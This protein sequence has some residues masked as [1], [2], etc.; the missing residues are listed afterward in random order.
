MFVSL[1]RRPLLPVATLAL[2]WPV[3]LGARGCADP[4]PIGGDECDRS[5]CGV[6]LGLPTITC[7]DGS[8]GGNTG[9]CIAQGDPATCGWEVRECPPIACS[10]TECGPVPPVVPGTT[11]TCERLADGTC[12]WTPSTD[13]SCSDPTSCGPAPGIPSWL[14]ADGSA[15][16]FTG[17]CI[18][19]AAGTCEWEVRACDPTTECTIAECGP[20][21]GSP[22]IV[23]ADG[24][25][26]GNTGHCMRD[27]AT[28]SCGWEQ[29]ACPTTPTTCAGFAGTACPAGQACIFGVGACR[30]P[31]AQGVCVLP[32]EACT[33]EWAPVCG[34]DDRT[35]SNPC[36]AHGSGVSILHGGECASSSTT[37]G[38]IAG[39]G[40]PS[41]QY[42]DY[43]V[44]PTGL[45]CGVAD[46]LGECREIPGACPDVVMPV[47]GCDGTTYGNACEAAAAGISVQ[48]D[49]AC[50]GG[51]TS[52]G[53]FGGVACPS[54]QYC[55]YPVDPAVG[56]SCGAADGTGTCTTIP[57]ACP[58]VVMPVCGCDGTTYYNA[59]AAGA[60]GVSVQ[61]AGPC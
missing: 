25:I 23:C 46:A 37:C 38:G 33:E 56:V 6:A 58:A 57:D 7:A 10:T 12:A 59:C 49:G 54:G 24:S 26:G 9:R 16:G 18:A 14:C 39:F 5:A 44:D 42:C 22:A 52:C 41:G 51:G 29:R 35:Y 47:C 55:D 19:S 48:H 60:A 28:G 20:M 61:H 27:P 32:P 36:H 1:S 34:C 45:A 2:L 40:C 13:P 8:T 21:P 17:R 4:V 30:T 50:A 43:A 11:V 53:G 15:G 3:L 31:D